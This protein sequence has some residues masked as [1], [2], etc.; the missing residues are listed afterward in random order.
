MNTGRMPFITL[1]GDP[2]SRGR[3]HGEA[4]A[5]AIHASLSRLK[6]SSTNETW[7]RAERLAGRSWLQLEV[8][9]PEIVAEIRGIAEGSEISPLCAYLLS[10]FEFFDATPPGGCTTVAVT[11]GK[12]AV[13]AQNWDALPGTEQELA[14]LLHQDKDHGVVMVASPGTLGWVGMNC[15]GLALVT[16][17]LIVDTATQGVPSLVVRRLLLQEQDVKGVL[18][19]LRMT[20][21]L[22]GRCYL[23]G[24]ASGNVS[25]CEISPSI[26]C[27]PLTGNQIVHTNHPITPPVAIM[28]DIEAMARIYPSSRERMRSANNL[29]LESIG[30]IHRLLRNTTGAPDAICKTASAREPTQTAFSVV[31]ECRDRRAS[32][33]LGRPDRGVYHAFDFAHESAA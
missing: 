17:D 30:D 21:H 12:K 18:A 14:M 31:F 5:T 28:E 20:N 22:S 32:I 23:V 19:R 13:V 3:Q 11:D 1:R 8:L 9:A 26:G 2:Y 7:S 29:S 4:L 27:V 15:A 6:R 16:N 24:D 33:C 10:G 25:G